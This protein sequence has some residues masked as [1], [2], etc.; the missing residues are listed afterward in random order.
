LKRNFSIKGLEEDIV[1]RDFANL[2]NLNSQLGQNAFEIAHYA[3]TE[4]LNN[5]IDH[6]FSEECFIEACLDQYHFTFLIRDYGVGL[7]QSIYTK[8]NL[9]DENA[10]IGELIKGKTTTWKEKHTGEGIF[11]TSKSADK[12]VFRSHGIE[13][14]FDNLKKDIFVNE[15]KRLKGTE[16]Y[17]NISKRS[18]R[19]LDSVFADFAPE[20]FDYRFDKT[21]V[22]VKLFHSDYVSRSEARRL[23]HG[24]EKFKEIILDFSGVKS[25]G[26]GFAD[27]IFRV[28]Q[29]AHPDITLKKINLSQTLEPIINHVVDNK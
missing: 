29:N 27:E 10:A 2:L 19:K 22:Q 25:M 20:E 1:F 21:K 14:I 24:L 4:M 8:F 3:F 23:L 12:L 18:R 13:V 7:F 15:K 9:A 16:V 28:F 11:F 5:A 6:S 26:Q 17:F